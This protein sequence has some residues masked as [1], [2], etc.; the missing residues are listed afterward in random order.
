MKANRQI[1]T[2]CSCPNPSVWVAAG[3]PRRSDSLPRQQ[4]QG[5][6]NDQ[7]NNC[8]IHFYKRCVPGP[9]TDGSL[10]LS[11]LGLECPSLA[12]PQHIYAKAKDSLIHCVNLLKSTHGKPLV[13]RVC[14][15]GARVPPDRFTSFLLV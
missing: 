3:A 8:L 11:P 14:V 13:G 12:T 6:L 10:A 1:S 9:V 15:S 5:C 2:S 4:P 7:A